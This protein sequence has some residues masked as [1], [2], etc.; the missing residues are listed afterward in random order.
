MAMVAGDEISE[1]HSSEQ[2][3]RDVEILSDQT[4]PRAGAIPV[5]TTGTP[6]QMDSRM[7]LTHPTLEFSL[8]Q[9]QTLQSIAKLVRRLTGMPVAIWFADSRDTCLRISAADGVSHRYL[10]QSFKPGDGSIASQV[11]KTGTL[12]TVHNIENDDRFRYK[13]IARQAGWISMRG[14][15]I[16]V[17]GQTCGVIEVFSLEGQQVGAPEL[18]TLY[19]LADIIG[20]TVESIYGLRSSQE[21]AWI[22]RKLSSIPDFGRAMQVLVESACEI[23][24]ADS[25]TIILLDKQ[26]NK[27]VIGARAP[28]REGTPINLPRSE[29]GLTR[30]ILNTGRP[31]RIDNTR[32]DSRVKEAVIS[33]GVQ[34]LIGV[35]VQMEDERVGALYVNAH[36]PSHF[37]DY[38]V[39]LLQMLADY[40]SVAFNWARL[41]IKPSIQME[42]STSRLFKLESVLTSVCEDLKKSMGFDFVTLQLVRPAERFIETVR[43]TGISSEWG[44]LAWKHYLE[45]DKSLR[46]I[47]ADIALNSPPRTEIIGGWDE[48]FDRWIYKRYNHDRLVRVFLPLIIVHNKEGKVIDKWLKGRRWNVVERK[49]SA[50]GWSIALEMS[51]PDIDYDCIQVIGTVEAGYDDPKKKVTAKQ[52]KEL[53]HLASQHALNIWQARL[54]CGLQTIAECAMHIAGADSASLHFIYSPQQQRYVYEVSCGR[55]GRDFLNLH[56]PREGGLGHQAIWSKKPKFVPNFSQNNGSTQLERLNP[57]IFQMGI[58]AMAAFPLLVGQQEGVLYVHFRRERHFT[59]DEIG[60]VQLFVNWAAD[61]VGHYTTY[62]QMRERARQLASLHAVVQFLV[63][64]PQ[65]EDLLRH[66][67]WNTLNSLG[68]DVVTIYEYIEKDRHFSDRPAIAGRLRSASKIQVEVDQETAPWQLVNGGKN[69]YEID[70]INHPV[71]NRAVRKMASR[72]GSPFVVREGIKSSA[73]VR[74]KVGEET[75]GAM[76][77][78]YRRP[79]DFSEEERITIEILASAAA[80]AIKNKR[81]LETLG[82]TLGESLNEGSREIITT[83]NLCDVLK[84][85]V[86]RAVMIT[87]ADVGVISRLDP[88]TQELVIDA[89]HPSTESI[90]WTRMKMGNGLTGWVAAN[91]ESALVKKLKA[92]KRH[93]RFCIQD[94]SAL[95][96]PLTNK[97]GQVL[98][99]LGVKS[100]KLSAFTRKHKNLLETLAN[101]AVIAIE[102]AESQKNLVNINKMATLGDLASSL[103]H[104]MEKKI[105][106][107]QDCVRRIEKVKNLGMARDTIQSVI[108][109]LNEKI[110][111]LNTWAETSQDETIHQQVDLRQAVEEAKSHVIRPDNIKLVTDLPEDVPKIKGEEPQVVEVFVNL[112]RNAIDAIPKRKRGKISVIAR[113]IKI[114]ESNWVS[115]KVRDTGVGIPRKNWDRIFEAKY[116]TKRTDDGHLGFG[117]WWTKIYVERLGGQIMMTSQVKKGTEFELL[118]PSCKQ[119]G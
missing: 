54:P 72:R 107:L 26:T 85:V 35:R 78:N 97:E 37:T 61:A 74:L 3:T 73:G 94:G 115:V 70:S 100:R 13:D 86:K 29:G 46:D 43:G 36:H 57:E 92:D 84:L 47:Q 41:L 12:Q 6:T 109:D 38:D 104:W 79:H 28:V 101:Y 10:T 14:L 56:Q 32:K 59:E 55:L 89:K 83:L 105:M 11:V 118:L 96:V 81:L 64:N 71:F 65:E 20:V 113:G 119:S 62:R 45:E 49:K 4:S 23:T 5:G 48:R 7:T 112:L 18:D 103:L 27:F 102:N 1:I 95:C 90:E 30:E 44:T 80:V 87:K 108:D 76:F 66:V 25:G 34:S 88:F 93:S 22:A 40:A 63:S 116:S 68:A 17:Q 99:V 51:S 110:L 82:E 60:W 98:G 53:V 114:G 9:K 21:L 58:R 42:Q 24:R 117:L 111:R 39:S 52:A 69:I 31:I 106:P 75:L 19:S 67:A 8:R 33:E 91:K 2:D 50:E 16:K 15:P 77:I